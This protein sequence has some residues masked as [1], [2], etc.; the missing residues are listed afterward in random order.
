MGDKVQAETIID[1]TE[2]VRA[3]L[4]RWDGTIKESDL[5]NVDLGTELYLKWMQVSREE[6]VARAE[7]AEPVIVSDIGSWIA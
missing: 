2:L 5:R 4:L 7:L 6:A 1:Q 3:M